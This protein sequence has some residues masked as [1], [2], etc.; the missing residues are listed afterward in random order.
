MVVIISA[1]VFFLIT[2]LMNSKEDQDKVEGDDDTIDDNK[3]KLLSII[4]YSLVI[5]SS[6]III[7]VNLVLIARINPSLK[8]KIGPEHIRMGFF[9]QIDRELIQSGEL[10]RNNDEN[11]EGKNVIGRLSDLLESTNKVYNYTR[12]RKRNCRKYYL[13]TYRFEIECSN[14]RNEKSFYHDDCEN[15]TSLTVDVKYLEGNLRDGWTYPSYNCVINRG[16]TKCESNCTNLIKSSYRLILF[17]YNEKGEENRKVLEAAWSGLSKNEIQPRIDLTLD[18]SINPCA[19]FSMH[20]SY[21]N[22]VLIAFNLFLN[23]FN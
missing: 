13:L 22:C 21:F 3:L 4:L 19:S 12:C 7:L 20:R 6:L 1:S 18:E 9:N 5:I 10:K 17:Q 23:I 11:D 14:K 16:E 15:A 2:S 8:T